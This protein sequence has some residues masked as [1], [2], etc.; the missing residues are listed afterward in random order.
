MAKSISVYDI[1]HFTLS[2][3]PL[4]FRG[5]AVEVQPSRNFDSRKGEFLTPVNLRYG[6][7]PKIYC[8]VPYFYDYGT[9][10]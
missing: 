8:T 7:V 1:I 3:V 9:I 4:G 5:L 2:I 6:T 10:K